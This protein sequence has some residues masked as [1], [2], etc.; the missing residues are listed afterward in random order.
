MSIIYKWL[1]IYSVFV[2]WMHGVIN[3]VSIG[4]LLNLD[5]WDSARWQ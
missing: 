4:P 5:R 3:I 2:L 1:T